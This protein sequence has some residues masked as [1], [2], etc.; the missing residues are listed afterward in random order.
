MDRNS[1]V[2]IQAILC[3]G[4]F[5]SVQTGALPKEGKAGELLDKI[6]NAIRENYT[7]AE[8]LRIGQDTAEAV[9]SA[10]ARVNE[11]VFAANEKVQYGKPLDESEDEPIHQVYA[12][13]GGKVLRAGIR[14]D[15]GMYV[16][17]EHQDKISTYGHLSN[18]AVITGE[19]VKKGDM[20]GSYDSS[21]E[22]E[23]Y[24]VLEEKTSS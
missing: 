4:I 5:V 11:A 1:K 22:K 23:F 12:V 20:I 15:I 6:S 19:R 3:L 10:P 21:G 8:L 18:A 14:D 16:K 2:M 9:A 13:A 7:L 17:V 24:Y